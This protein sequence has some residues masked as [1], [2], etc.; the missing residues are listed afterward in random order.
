MIITQIAQKNIKNDNIMIILICKKNSTIM[1]ISDH[2][3]YKN[4]QMNNLMK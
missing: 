4:I 2:K 1:I 3:I